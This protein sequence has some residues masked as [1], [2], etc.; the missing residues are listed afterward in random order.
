VVVGA[1]LF[2]SFFFDIPGRGLIFSK[3]INIQWKDVGKL[4]NG[5]GIL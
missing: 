4:L 1:H 3:A 5:P 2:L